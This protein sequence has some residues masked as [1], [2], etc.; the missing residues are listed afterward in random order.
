MGG[1]GSVSWVWGGSFEIGGCFN[2]SR[3]D[4]IRIEWLVSWLWSTIDKQ[5]WSEE[6]TN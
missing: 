1:G 4:C 2:V 3:S 6:R 5:G